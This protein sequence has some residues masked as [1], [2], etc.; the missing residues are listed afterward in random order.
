M[1]MGASLQKGQVLSEQFCRLKQEKKWWRWL[2]H[3]ALRLSGSECVCFS[4]VC[5]YVCVLEKVKM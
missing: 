1:M 5:A 3:C 4:L 2:H